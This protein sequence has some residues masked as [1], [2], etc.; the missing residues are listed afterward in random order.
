MKGFGVKCN[1]GYNR[2]QLTKKEQ[3]PMN[4]KFFQISAITASLLATASV[5]AADAKAGIVNFATILS[6][7]KHGQNEQ[8]SFEALKKQ[9]TSLLE[10]T[11]KQLNEI[12]QKFNDPDYVDGLSPEGEAEMK[13]KFQVLSEEMNRYQNQYYQVMQQ[14]NMRLIQVMTTH[15]NDASEKLAK[16]NK[17]AY[18]I[19]KD[20]CFYYDPSLD[21]TPQIMTEMNTSFEKD[22]LAKKTAATAAKATK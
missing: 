14:A 17:L 13:Q 20:A 19:N 15:I 6:E 16:K 9:M 8:E 22:E 2:A 18:I 7:S 21:V 11:E 10:D 1:H 3:N 5:K 12:A 4:K